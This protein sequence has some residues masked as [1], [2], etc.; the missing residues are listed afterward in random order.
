[1]TNT[2]TQKFVDT[3]RVGEYAAQ[4]PVSGKTRVDETFA[5]NGLGRGGYVRE[6]KAEAD[7]SA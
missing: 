1:M 6:E 2:A 7:K 4:Q 3:T 5:V